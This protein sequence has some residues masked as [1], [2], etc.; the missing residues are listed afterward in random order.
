MPV[1]QEVYAGAK[2]TTTPDLA[3]RISLPDG[4]S[5]SERESK[6]PWKCRQNSVRGEKRDDGSSW[7]LVEFPLFNLPEMSGTD[8]QIPWRPQMSIPPQ[9]PQIINL[10]SRRPIK[11]VPVYNYNGFHH[12]Q[13]ISPYSYSWSSSSS[14]SSSSPKHRAIS[15]APT[16]LNSGLYSDNTMVTSRYTSKKI[17][18]APRMRWTSSLHARFVH[19]VELLGGH[20]SMHVSYKFLPLDL[21]VNQSF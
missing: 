13:K 10:D 18:R 17:V 8:Y 1:L 3:L 2:A 16:R 15:L 21:H 20:E 11:G 5:E 12:H 6:N 9:Q 4:T 19:A 14:T 7:G